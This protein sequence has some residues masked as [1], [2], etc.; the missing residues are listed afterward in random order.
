MLKYN[1]IKEVLDNYPLKQLINF[2]TQRQQANKEKNEV[3]TQLVVDDLTFDSY[4]LPG[5]Y[6]SKLSILISAL[7]TSN[8]KVGKRNFRKIWI[9]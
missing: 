8:T 9:S 1:E 3:A 4:S 7:I 2:Y 5:N 6:T